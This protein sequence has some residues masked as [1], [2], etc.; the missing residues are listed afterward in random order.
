MRILFAAA[1][2]LAM[3]SGPALAEDTVRLHAAGSLRAAMTDIADAYQNAR[4]TKVERAFGP[5]GLLRKRIE[6]GE[7]AEVF[8]SANMRHPGA[9]AE[10]GK[11]SP[12]AL[13]ARNKLCALA[14]PGVAIETATVLDVLLDPAVRVGT[15][16]PK[17][18]PS[19]D[20]AWQLFDKADEL[21]A[22]AGQ[23]LKSKALQLTGGPDSAKPPKGRN[24]YGW[25]M[26]EKRADVFLTYC[27]NAVLAERDTTGLKIVPLPASLSV[28]ADYGLTVMNDAPSGAWKLAMFILSPAGQKVLASYGFDAPGLPAAGR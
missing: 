12:V 27:T 24:P 19:G 13:F 18:D 7:A 14:Q 2:A 16:T 15:S 6:E 25:V 22:G 8:A 21:R 3:S 1:A 20:Y 26:S 11:S 9:L 17:A 23:T 5:S 10:A 28:G 4:S